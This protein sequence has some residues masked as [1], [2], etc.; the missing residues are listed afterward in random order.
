MEQC[1][2]VVDLARFIV[3]EVV[4]VQAFGTAAFHTDPSITVED[5][6]VVNTRFQS[7]ALG[8]FATG[9]FVAPGLPAVA[10]IGLTITSR[11]AVARF[12]TW[13]FEATLSEGERIEH[14]AAEP[15]IFTMQA[16]AFVDAWKT[17]DRSLVLCDY[18]DGLE[19]LKVGLAANEALGS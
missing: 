16:R 10:G 7:G 1:T 3:G 18:A 2:H 19:S 4:E 17:G 13:G 11:S 6:V 5:A 9:C 8:Q 12:S 15:D 14:F